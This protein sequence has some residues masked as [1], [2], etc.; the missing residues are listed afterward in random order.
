MDYFKIQNNNLYKSLQQKGPDLVD[1]DLIEY[2]YSLC[3]LI[4]KDIFNQ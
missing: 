2:A 4:G 3:T 1:V